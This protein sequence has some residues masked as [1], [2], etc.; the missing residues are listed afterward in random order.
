MSLSNLADLGQDL[1]LRARAGF[2]YGNDAL[3]NPAA[4]PSLVSDAGVADAWTVAEPIEPTLIELSKI[5]I[6]PEDETATG[7][8]FPRQYTIDV[9]IA[10]GQ[11]LTNLDITDLLPNNVL[12]LSV[13]AITPAGSTTTLPVTPANPT[14]NELVVTL[15]TVTGAVGAGDAQVTFFVLHSSA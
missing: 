10:D 3:D 9:D 2:Q 14:D 8:N 6:G 7:P 1:N 11:T 4:D 5:Y 13:D 12:L 15:P